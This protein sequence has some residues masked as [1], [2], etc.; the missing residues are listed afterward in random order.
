[1][2]SSG[3]AVSIRG[4]RWGSEMSNRHLEL[5]RE[6][7]TKRLKKIRTV[8]FSVE[9]HQIMNGMKQLNC[10]LLFFTHSYKQKEGHKV[11][12][13]TKRLIKSRHN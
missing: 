8:L 4:M 1:M 2:F 6:F 7:H 5:W 9:M 10:M 11:K 3:K 13:E 12:T